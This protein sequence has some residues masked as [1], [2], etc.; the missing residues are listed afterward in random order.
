MRDVA[1]RL[2]G[3]LMPIVVDAAVAKY[4]KSKPVTTAV[5]VRSGNDC[6]CG[7]PIALPPG[8]ERAQSARQAQALVIIAQC[9]GVKNLLPQT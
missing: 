2:I 9:P 3:V 1:H 4:S 8:F 6:Q 7:T 5:R